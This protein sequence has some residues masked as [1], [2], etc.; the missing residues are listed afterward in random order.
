MTCTIRLADGQDLDAI[1]RV[2]LDSWR[3]A[4]SAL[5]PEMV[6]RRGDLTETRKQTWA[7]VLND[8]QYF[9]YAAS[10]DGELVGAAQGG[11]VRADLAPFGCDGEL[12]RLY[13]LTSAQGKGVGRAL[14]W[15]TARRLHADGFRSMLVTA[16]AINQPARRFYERCGAEF[17]T[18][19]RQDYRGHD[20]SQAVYRWADIRSAF[21]EE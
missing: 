19:M 12:H 10:L 15:Q 2:H 16:W 20:T 1:V 18:I 14:V 4:F 17:V 13:V 6:A 3:A 8:P 9:V 5:L 21:G 7:G 11:P